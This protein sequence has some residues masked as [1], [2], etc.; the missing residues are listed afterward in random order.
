MKLA[1]TSEVYWSSV[2]NEGE[3]PCGKYSS[4]SSSGGG[5]SG[6]SSSR[7]SLFLWTAAVDTEAALVVESRT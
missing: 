4:S 7:V 1:A 5:S 2:H 3:S 6:S